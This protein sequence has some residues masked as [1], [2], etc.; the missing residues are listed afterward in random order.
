MS[1]QL[2]PVSSSSYSSKSAAKP[3]S[4]QNSSRKQRSRSRRMRTQSLV[5]HRS[6]PRFIR[7]FWIPIVGVLLPALHLTALVIF[8]AVGFDNNTYYSLLVIPLLYIAGVLMAQKNRSLVVLSN[9][10]NKSGYWFSSCTFLYIFFLAIL[11]G[12]H[13]YMTYLTVEEAGE[14]LIN[15]L[16]FR[17]SLPLLILL[18]GSII[19]MQRT[20]MDAE[21]SPLSSLLIKNAETGYLEF[22]ILQL[23]DTFSLLDETVYAQSDT[24]RNIIFGISMLS[25]IFLAVSL[26]EVFNNDYEYQYSFSRNL[27]HSRLFRMVSHELP[28]II[29]RLLLFIESNFESSILSFWFKNLLTFIVMSVSS[30]DN[31]KHGIPNLEDLESSSSSSG[32]STDGESD[33][34]STFILSR[35]SDDAFERA[36]EF[37]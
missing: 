13:Q 2:N 11:G 29:L 3:L 5:F 17:A 22:V 4:H 31:W 34:P 7:V 18:I 14:A 6:L 9:P 35:L 12:F 26:S 30:Y 28:F 1:T 25:L 24:L 37:V 21:I 23:L 33:A 20:G 32:S 8:T 16:V 10:F 36:P 27:I 15:K 19:Y